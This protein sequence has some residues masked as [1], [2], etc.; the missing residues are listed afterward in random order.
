[1]KHPAIWL[2]VLWLPAVAVAEDTAGLWLTENGDA[3]VELRVRGDELVGHIVWLEDARYAAD[4]PGGRA[5]EPLRDDENPHPELRAREL[6]GLKIVWGFEQHRQGE[7]RGGRAYDPE[8]GRTYRARL[9][10]EDEGRSLALRGYVGTPMLGRTSRW[11]RLETLPDGGE[12]D[13]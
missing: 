12:A 8:N 2:W 6:L 10:L 3:A 7:W 5:G 11:T 9:R 4:D 1:M 13:R